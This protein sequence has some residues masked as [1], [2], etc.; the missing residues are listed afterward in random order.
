MASMSCF[1]QVQGNK[2]RT[3]KWSQ[4]QVRMETQQELQTKKKVLLP[5]EMQTFSSS[6]TPKFLKGLRSGQILCIIKDSTHF[7]YLPSTTKFKLHKRLSQG[8]A[9]RS[10][11]SA[12][13]LHKQITSEPDVF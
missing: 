4:L 3:L 2:H 1:N 13:H 12:K 7:L 6:A 10:F 5:D 9:N 8:K 11:T